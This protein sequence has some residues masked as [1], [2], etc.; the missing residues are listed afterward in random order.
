[1]GYE[2]DCQDS[3]P[4]GPLHSVKTGFGAQTA[5]YPEVKRPGCEVNH[6]RPPN[7]ELKNSEA[8]P[9]LPHVPA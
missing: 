6:S 9:P 8:T 4:A 3:V 7:A 2:L 5:S 1:M